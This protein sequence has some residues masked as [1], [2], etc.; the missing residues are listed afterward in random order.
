MSQ[1]IRVLVVDDSPLIRE[2]IADKIRE[3]PG[4]ELAGTAQ[5]GRDALDVFGRVHA[6]VVTLDVQMPRM[7]GL[8]TLKELLAR[9][10]VAVIMVSSLTRLGADIT[11]EALEAGAL[12]FVAKPEGIR[13]SEKTFTDLMRKIGTVANTDVAHVL[14]IRRKRAQRRAA[15]RAQREAERRDRAAAREPQTVDPDSDAIANKLRDKCIALGISTGGPPALTTL[16][17]SLRTPLPP[18]VVVQHMPEHFT[19]QFATRLNSISRLCVKEAETGD[20]LEPNCVYVAPGGRH[21][22]IRAAGRGGRIVIRDGSPVS[23]HRP[24][25]DVMMQ[26][27]AEIYRNRCLGIIMTGMGRDGAD[28][29][30]YIRKAGGYVMG[31]DQASSDVYGMNKVAFVEGNVDRQFSLDEA[32]GTINVQAKRL[33]WPA[34]ANV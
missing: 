33:W 4:V 17:E 18:V 8:Q 22:T 15:T 34:G 6:D 7:D 21:L 2:M 3:T 23:G 24:S 20:S 12:D 32:A 14:D 16:F 31:Q 28:G 30:G 10:P 13:E 1:Q 9:R 5:D 27:A 19:K 29:C 11:L 26:A 25:V